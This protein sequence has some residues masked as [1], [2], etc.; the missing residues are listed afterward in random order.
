MLSENGVA[1]PKNGWQGKMREIARDC[2]VFTDMQGIKYD[3]ALM[4]GAA[5]KALGCIWGNI[6]CIYGRLC[7]GRRKI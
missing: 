4:V 3:A 1:L 5:R 7:R 2:N 6:R